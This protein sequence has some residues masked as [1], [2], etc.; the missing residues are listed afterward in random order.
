[1]KRAVVAAVAVF[2]ALPGSAAADWPVFGH[3]LGN[4]RNA[5]SDGPSR[6]EAAS[7]R[8]AWTF[9]SSRGDFTGTPVVAAGTLVAGTNLGEVFALEAATGKVLWSRDAGAPINGSA[10]IDLN[11]PGGPI[12]LIPV[13]A[14]D[15]P[16]LVALS[17]ATGAM[18]WQTVL[19]RQPGADVYGS[20]VFWRGSVYIGTG[21]PGNDESN[22][23]GSVASLDEASGRM[24]WQTF[25]V[26]PGDDGGG[27]WCTPTIDPATGRLYVGTGNAYHDPAA[28]TTDS[29]VSMSAANGHILAHFQ[30]VPGD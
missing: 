23:R 27:V 7:M 30:S 3:D 19:T 29:M 9:N 11:A 16:R 25:I 22:A 2:L 8:Q 10:A 1:M 13:A 5:G 17:L 15:A 28:D 4:S 24:R 21:G 20:P 26:P 6:A 18:R 14:L 12:A